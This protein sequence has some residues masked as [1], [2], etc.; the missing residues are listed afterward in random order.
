VGV[1]TGGSSTR[2][3]QHMSSTKKSKRIVVAVNPTASFGATR[4]VGPALVTTLRGL[5]HDVTML[6]EADYV[7][8]ITTAKKAVASKPDAFVVVGGDG[9]VNLGTNLVAG[10]KVPLGIVPSGTGNDMAR[11]LGIPIG[12]LEQAVAVLEEALG[13]PPRVIDAGMITDAN[14][15]SRWFGCIVSAGFDSVVN[16]RAN[17]MRYP[18]GKSRYT[19]ALLLE[20]IGLKPISY[21][22]VMDGTELVTKGML[23]SVGNGQSLGGGMRVTPDALLDDGLLDVLV[24]EPLTRIQFLRIFPK[25]FKGTHIEDPRVNVTRARTVRLE[26]DSAVA[27][28]DGERFAPLPVDIEIRPG[29]LLVLSPPV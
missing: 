29:A 4:A 19:A 23:V 18:K 9:M 5:G 27:Y 22:I 26:S 8:L 12:N 7:Q 15:E 3:N 28:T 11:A 10:T 13:R 20:M 17:H 16:E 21:R 1:S 6:V 14:G 25:V 2:H 24:V